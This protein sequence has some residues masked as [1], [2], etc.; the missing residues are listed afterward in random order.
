MTGIGLAAKP[1]KPMLRPRQ[2]AGIQEEVRRLDHMLKQPPHVLEHVDVP[3]AMRQL[4]AQKVQL[5]ECTPR[6]FVPEERDAAVKEEVE[7]R[8][9]IRGGMCTQEEMR[10]NPA[11]AVDKHRSWERRAKPLIKRW[12]NNRLRQHATEMLGDLPAD[13][14]DVANIEIFRPSGGAQQLN[15]DHAQIP[16]KSFYLPERIVAQNVADDEDKERWKVQL[17]ELMAEA[18]A[19]GDKRHAEALASLVGDDRAKEMIEEKKRNSGVPAELPT[20]RAKK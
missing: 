17:G 14:T 9:Q 5:D 4:K 6:P 19:N 16:G 2:V 3:A 11:G 15:M 20:S 12:K 13:A 18:A 10:R 7:L 8:E 1:E